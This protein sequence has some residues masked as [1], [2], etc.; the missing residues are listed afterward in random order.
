MS[1]KSTASGPGC[2]LRRLR[3]ARSLGRGVAAPLLALLLLLASVGAGAA[4]SG[5]PAPG[6]TGSSTAAG[7]GQVSGLA[8][9]NQPAMAQGLVY[10]DGQDT[11][12]QVREVDLLA[13]AEAPS[14]AGNARFIIQRSGTS[15][16]RNDVTGKRTLLEVHESYFAAAGDPYTAMAADGSPSTV[17]IVEVANDDAVGEG[18]FYLSPPVTGLGEATYDLELVRTTLNPGTTTAYSSGAEPFLVVVLSG[19][20]LVDDGTS[21][22]TLV[23][24]EARSAQSNVAITAQGE[25]AAVYVVVSLGQTVSDSSIG[26]PVGPTDTTGTDTTPGTTGTTG[27]AGATDTTDAASSATTTSDADVPAISA[28][29]LPGVIGD[30]VTGDSGTAGGAAQVTEAPAPQTGDGYVTSIAVRAVVPIGVTMIV[31]GVTVFDGWLETGDWTGYQTG[32]TFEV[33]TTSGVNTDFTNTCSDVPFQMGSEEGDA[34]YVLEAGPQ[35]CAPI[36]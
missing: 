18:A 28:G 22:A 26:A 32:T 30:A 2:P 35:S 23:E 12:W 10:L 6:E 24:S 14:S 13:P 27:T 20:I 29:D 34:Y 25:D 31:D 21:E 1:I 17:W 8:A 5:T 4:Q 19:Q 16:I 33:Y 7:A 3:L 11:V 36:E 9:G 15:V